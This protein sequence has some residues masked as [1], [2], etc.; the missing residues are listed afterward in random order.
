[1]KENKNMEV[2][3]SSF[4]WE[5]HDKN[6]LLG[7][8]YDYFG[9]LDANKIVIIPRNHTLKL[10][11]NENSNS[12]AKVIYSFVG[13]GVLGFQTPIMVDGINEKGLMGALLNYPGYAVY[14]TRKS[15]ETIN[16]YPGFFLTYIL[17]QCS[18][19][20]EVVSLLPNINLNNEEVYGKKT[21]VHFI[22]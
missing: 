9:N 19:L 14:D 12:T 3:C 7:R 10:E 5:T 11:I 16:I 6:H 15:D 21:Q 2:G 8:T 13:M 17:S 20:D 1:V 4:T 18:N 22:F